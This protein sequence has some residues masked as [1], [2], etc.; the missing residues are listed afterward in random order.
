MK[1]NT[2]SARPLELALYGGEEYELV[3]TV[4]PDVWENAKDA[5]EYVGGKLTKIGYATK[6]QKIVVATNGTEV[7]VNTRG[8]EHF[9]TD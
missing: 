3:I 6:E 1:L 2:S 9:K 8:W 7:S 5:V 4:N